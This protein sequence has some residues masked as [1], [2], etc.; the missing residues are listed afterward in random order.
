V[1]Y[2]NAVA[3]WTIPCNDKINY[4]LIKYYCCGASLLRS[5]LKQSQWLQW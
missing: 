1:I 2:S 4:Y 5:L 3:I